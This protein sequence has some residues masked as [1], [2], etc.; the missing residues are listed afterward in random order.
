MTHTRTRFHFISQSV[1]DGDVHPVHICSED[2]LTD[3]LTKAL[4]KHGMFW[5][6]CSKSTT[7]GGELS[8]NKTCALFSG[9]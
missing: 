2:Q 9:Y 5:N 7:L 4:P 8:C 6:V 1:E 3:V